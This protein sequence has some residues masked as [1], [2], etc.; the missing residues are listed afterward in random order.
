MELRLVGSVRETWHDLGLT[1]QMS[2]TM[3]PAVATTL[4][5]GIHFPMH[6]LLHTCGGDSSCD[7]DNWFLLNPLSEPALSR[8]NW[9]KHYSYSYV[10][11]D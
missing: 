8:H 11:G 5:S 2:E 7:M 10:E 3:W 9:E 6:V 1:V 4:R